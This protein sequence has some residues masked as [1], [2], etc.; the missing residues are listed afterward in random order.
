MAGLVMHGDVGGFK[1]EGTEITVKK[2]ALDIEIGAKSPEIEDKTKEGE[3]EGDEKE[4]EKRPK[5]IDNAPKAEAAN[6]EPRATATDPS[7]ENDKIEK[8]E[9]AIDKN[10]RNRKSKFSVTGDIDFSGH[11]I[12]IGVFYGRQA[13]AKEREWLVYTVW[14]C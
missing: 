11:D 8:K 2:A 6:S 5:A 1:L 4:K 13:R 7:A 14:H 12:R 9:N 10:L 3:K